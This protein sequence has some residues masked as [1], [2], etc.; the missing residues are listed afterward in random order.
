MSIIH[1]LVY[2]IQ[3]SQIRLC[4]YSEARM[5]ESIIILYIFTAL[6]GLYTK[7]LFFYFI[8]LDYIFLGPPLERPSWLSSSPVAFL[9]LPASP[10]K[11]MR[12]PNHH[13]AS[14]SR[15][16]PLSDGPFLRYTLRADVWAGLNCVPEVFDEK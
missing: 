2:T 8:S 7:Y 3:P 12:S 15:T 13:A 9:F 16:P 5:H 6:V 14:F 11:V 4:S 10:M 1:T